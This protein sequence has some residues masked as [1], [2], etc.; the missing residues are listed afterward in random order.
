MMRISSLHS[1][2]DIMI[3]TAVIARTQFLWS[4]AYKDK[5]GM[6]EAIRT[7]ITVDEDLAALLD[8]TEFSPVEMSGAQKVPGTAVEIIELMK[9]LKRIE[10]VNIA[11]M[12][13]TIPG[14][15]LE[16]EERRRIATN[17]KMD[18]VGRF[19]RMLKRALIEQFDGWRTSYEKQFGKM[20]KLRAPR[21]K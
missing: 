14:E 13:K 16:L 7:S 5:E 19:F 17:H 15:P 21:V 20:L 1:I 12:L 9:K 11:R 2:L 4:K 8:E 3:E 18:S 10:T 6:L